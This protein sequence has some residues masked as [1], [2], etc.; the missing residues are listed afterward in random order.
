VSAEESSLF[1]IIY[2]LKMLFRN[3]NYITIF[4]FFLEKKNE[5]ANSFLI[6]NNLI[7]VMNAFM[8]LVDD[9]LI[10]LRGILHIYVTF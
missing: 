2:C 9:H 7:N 10:S 3:E 8:H 4:Y 1:Y 5:E 6:A